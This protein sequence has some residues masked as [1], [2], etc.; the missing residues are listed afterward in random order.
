MCARGVIYG[1]MQHSTMKT[2]TRNIKRQYE[3]I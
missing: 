1:K 2:V 3:R